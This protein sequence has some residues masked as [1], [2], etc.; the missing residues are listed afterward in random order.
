[1]ALTRALLRGLGLDEEKIATVIEAHTETV[2]GLKAKIAEVEKARDEAIEAG[3]GG[4]E[5]ETKYKELTAEY[6]KYK[7][8]QDAKGVRSAKEKAFR[9]LLIKAG[10]SEKRIDSVIKVSD[11]DSVELDEKGK[12]KDEKTLAN[13]IKTDWAD[14]ITTSRTTGARVDT[15][16][17]STSGGKTRDEIMAIKDR[18]ERLKAIK[19]NPQAFKN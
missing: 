9:E 15:P 1:M 2:D 14:F 13:S 16:P 17:T 3:K 12:L 6:E 19:D 10:V 18:G 4:S 7:A 8:D 11:I 5:W